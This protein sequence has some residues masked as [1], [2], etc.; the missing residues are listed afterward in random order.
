M[1]AGLLP[2]SS[3]MLLANKSSTAGARL[4]PFKW[5]HSVQEDTFI[6]GEHVGYAQERKSN[7]QIYP[8]FSVTRLTFLLYSE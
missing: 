5:F 3:L 1:L 6:E 7:H 4:L 2:H 8:N